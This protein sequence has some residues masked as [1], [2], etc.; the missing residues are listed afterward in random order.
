[1]LSERYVL[2]NLI[3]NAQYWTSYPLPTTALNNPVFE[4]TRYWRGPTWPITNLFVIEGLNQN[5]ENPHCLQIRDELIQ[6]TCEMISL[7]GFYEYFDPT[8]GDARPDKKEDTKALG[9]GSFSW[10]AAIYVYLMKEYL[11]N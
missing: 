6:K 11:N 10:T 5:K 3:D 4:L 9:F 2:T 7:N 1:M 8:L